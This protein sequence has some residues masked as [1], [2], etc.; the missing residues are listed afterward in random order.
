[1]SLKEECLRSF[2]SLTD[3]HSKS[4]T[5]HHI[6]P[7]N[8]DEEDNGDIGVFC[9]L[10]LKNSATLSDDGTRNE[11]GFADG[12]LSLQMRYSFLQEQVC[13]LTQVLSGHGIT[14]EFVGVYYRKIR[15]GNI[16]FSNVRGIG[17]SQAEGDT[18]L[19]AQNTNVL[20]TTDRKSVHS[21]S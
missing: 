15:E 5:L 10:Y 12:W 19:A 4:G 16:V 1:M 20:V 17:T 9:R 11:L 3:P 14:K 8:E 21:E 6:T 18:S 7:L 13:F 2:G